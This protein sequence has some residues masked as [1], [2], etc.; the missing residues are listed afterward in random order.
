MF[1]REVFAEYLRDDL[2]TQPKKLRRN[3]EIAFEPRSFYLVE[4][5]IVVM[6]KKDVV[7]ILGPG[8]MVGAECV[9]PGDET[10]SDTGAAG[11]ALVPGTSLYEIPGQD[12]CELL[13]EEPK[14]GVAL[15]QYLVN[16]NMIFERR[17]AEAF[18][19]QTPQ[20][21]A[22]ALL[23]LYS[24]FGSLDNNGQQVMP[25]FPHLL[26]GEFIGTTRE[27]VT[28]NMN[29]FK[30]SGWISYSR[31]EMFILNETALGR[32]VRRE[33]GENIAGEQPAAQQD[34]A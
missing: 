29:I 28:H 31:K 16:T 23:Y 12:V 17:L 7:Y 11:Y 2:L 6:A 33:P 34:A 30:R 21:L 24:Q 27:A 18:V 10:A 19:L 8:D 20:R 22:S 32:F 14:A 26:L 25:P 3:E 15:V 4:T 5:G 13:L 9:L 1:E